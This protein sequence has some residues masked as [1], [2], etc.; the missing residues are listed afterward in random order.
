[1][2]SKALKN[3]SKVL[4]NTDTSVEQLVQAG[5]RAL[6]VLYGGKLGDKLNGLRYKKFCERT[7]TKKIYLQSQTLPPTAASVKYHSMRVYLHTGT[8][9][10]RC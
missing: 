9:L 8:A 1:M 10:T 3:S 7:A 2:M 6:V 5:E 4:S